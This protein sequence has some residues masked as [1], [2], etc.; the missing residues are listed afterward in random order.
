VAEAVTDP[1]QAALLMQQSSARGYPIREYPQTVAN[2]TT[3]GNCFFELIR[4]CRLR[5]YPGAD[6]LR[7]HVLACTA[8]ETDRGIRLVKTTSSRKID[9]AVA[10][11]MAAR[12]GSELFQRWAGAWLSLLQGEERD[13][14]LED[15]GWIEIRGW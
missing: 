12:V 4:Q 5:V 7:T 10:L 8:K 14:V 9:A 2:M 11:A 6:D 1:Y 3:A 15:E 13:A